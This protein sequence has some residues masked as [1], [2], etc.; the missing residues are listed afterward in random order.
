MEKDQRMKNVIVKFRE[1]YT[2]ASST[3]KGVIEY[4]LENPE[5]VA[6]MGLRELAKATYVSSSTITRLCHKAGFSQYKDFQKSLIYENALRK[7]TITGKNCEIAK[8]D[9]LEQ[10]VDKIIYKS[11]V[12]LEDTK[13]LIDIETLDKSVSVM[14]AAQRI[15][16]F[17]MGA[18]LLVGKDAYL[19]F[20]RINKNCMANE[21][22]HMQMVQAKNLSNRDAAVIISYSG[23]TK[24]IVQCAEIERNAG[25]PVIAVTCFRESPLSKLANYN[26]YV[27]ATEFE[28]QTGKLASRLSQLAVIDMLY[29][30][31]IQHEYE[32]CMQ[33]LK[34]NY[35]PKTAKEREGEDD[36]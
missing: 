36:D 19:K 28:F 7:E 20:L 34:H 15:A 4:L 1:Y 31:C 23:M 16:F 17:G 25:A 22:I 24:E 18:S 6:E 8:D 29:S 5:K 14:M 2:E 13:A 32:A 10:L 9:K 11:I 26:L 30:A 33:Y 12:S 35:I 3:E 21:D 27:S